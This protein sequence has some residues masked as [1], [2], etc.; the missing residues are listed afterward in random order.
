MNWSPAHD[1]TL[2][3]PKWQ[4]ERPVTG[5]LSGPAG[6]ADYGARD[7]RVAV[8]AVDATEARR[9][10]DVLARQRLASVACHRGT[11]LARLLGEGLGAAIIDADALDS[12]GLNGLVEGL[13]RQPNWSDV[14]LVVL[15]DG[16][17]GMSGRLGPHEV[18]DTLESACHLTVL[19]RPV[20]INTLLSTVQSA[21]RTR[22]RQYEMRRLLRQLEEGV[23]QRDHLLSMLGHELRN[24]LAAIRAATELLL[25][26]EST[27]EPTESE[28]A[29]R[30]HHLELI[31]RQ[32]GQLVRMV[33]DLLDLGRMRSGRVRLLRVAVDLNVVVRR[34]VEA[35][36]SAAGQ[37]GQKLVA[38]YAPE[39]AV[40]EGDP[41]R[42]EQAMSNLL[43]NAVKYSAEGGT[44]AL[45]VSTDGLRE[46]RSGGSATV[47]IADS[48]VGMSPEVMR[49]V[50]DLFTQA[51]QSIDRP[52]GGLGLGLPLVQSLIEGHGGT[53]SAA[54]E[55]PGRGS[56][57]TVRLPLSAAS[58]KPRTNG[59]TC[60]EPQAVSRHVLLVEDQGDMRNV[61]ARLLRSWGHRVETAATGPAGIETALAGRPEVALVDVGLPGLSGYEVA[62]RLRLALDGNI[63]LIALTGYGTPEDRLRSAAAGFDLHLVKPVDFDQLRALLAE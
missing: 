54:S 23:A 52:L 7:A 15:T 6:G 31:A 40:V 60:P 32:G 11:D 10:R 63:R 48:G 47:R 61:M 4:V 37:R 53:V 5:S 36:G 51:D 38:S 35:A 28:V 8:L 1:P 24:P 9:L 3:F 55:G 56:L 43:A 17:I 30:R 14:P 2:S 13:R 20:A 21:L 39:P 34:C 26:Q 59:A 27:G 16:A 45:E 25:R 46:G 58:A 33:D 44:I 18:V 19:E 57:F 62:S 50:F 41:V 12:A 42:L 49:G 22:R 29:L